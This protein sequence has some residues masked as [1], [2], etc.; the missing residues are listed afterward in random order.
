MD[1]KTIVVAQFLDGAEVNQVVCRTPGEARQAI[2]DG[3]RTAAARWRWGLSRTNFID[4]HGADVD[5]DA[6]NKLRRACGVAER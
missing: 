1:R 4:E 2:A 6:A 3:N 5:I